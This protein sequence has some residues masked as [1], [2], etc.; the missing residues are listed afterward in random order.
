MAPRKSRSVKSSAPSPSPAV[1]SRASSRSRSKSKR[2]STDD[3]DVIPE[4]E[5]VNLEHSGEE[6][7]A[8]EEDNEEA[9]GGASDTIVEED[10]EEHEQGAEEPAVGDGV[11]EVD[12]RQEDSDVK[13]KGKMSMQDRMAKLKDL[14]M[15]MN[16]SSADNRKDLI[17]D[18]QKSK[19]TAKELQR[20]EKQRKLAQTLRLKAEAEENG[21]DLERK[22]AWEW[23][24]EQNER[25][26]AKMEESKR[27]SDTLFHNADDDAHKRYD[28]NIRTTKIDLVAYE[29]QKEAA[30]GLAPGTL[31]PAG[32][33][34]SS[35][36]AS[37]SSS[38]GLTAAEDLYRGADT[39][40]Y[41]DSKPSEDAIDRVVGKINSDMSKVK[42]KKKDDVDEE[43]TYINERNKVFNKKISRYFDKYTKEIRSNL[44][45]GTAL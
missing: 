24:I 5:D 28:K 32:A 21:E 1:S 19:V 7:E 26:E 45:R 11:G 38:R 37:S 44:E 33:T 15:R 6:E 18:H 36:K 42:R 20:L 43:I 22:K 8:D 9:K 13:G 12:E 17:A 31:V 25:W 29:R 16:K 10:G 4:E 2:Q 27:R 40:A 39:L 14:R 34:A 35:L 41:G 23:S 3:T 30:L